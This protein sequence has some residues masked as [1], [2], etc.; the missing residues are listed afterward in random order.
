MFFIYILYCQRS[1]SSFSLLIEVRSMWCSMQYLMPPGHVKTPSTFSPQ[2]AAT[3]RHVRMRH[4]RALFFILSCSWG[5][6]LWNSLS[7]SRVFTTPEG[8]ASTQSQCKLCRMPWW[9]CPGSLGCTDTKWD[10]QMITNGNYRS[11]WMCM[12]IFM[13]CSFSQIYDFNVCFFQPFSCKSS[14]TFSY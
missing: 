8:A 7:R 2:R 9:K 3:K 6:L 1:S 4:W 14:R 11:L 12:Q 13:P 5:S 10:I